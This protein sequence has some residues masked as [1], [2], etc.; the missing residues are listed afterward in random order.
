[1]R[2]IGSNEAAEDSALVD[3][4]LRYESNLHSAFSIWPRC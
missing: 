4:E 3:Q 2:S 1:M